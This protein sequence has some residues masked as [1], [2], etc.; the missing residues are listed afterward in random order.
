MTRKPAATDPLQDDIRLL[1]RLLGDT[2]AEQEGQDAFA[3][4]EQVRRLSVAY[5]RSGDAAAE[6]RLH[7]VLRGLSVEQMLSV[8]RAFTYFSH[9]ANLAEDRQHIRRRMWHE[10]LSHVQPGS[11]E[12]ALATLRQRGVSRQ[13]T[14]N[15]LAGAEVSPVLTAHPTEVQRQSVMLAERGISEL[16]TER[17]AIRQRALAV[18]AGLPAADR[19]AAQASSQAELAANE[20]GLR[21]HV[22]RL[23]QTRLLRD[24]RLTVRDE[25]ENALGYYRSTFLTEIPRLYERLEQRLPGADVAPFLRMGHWMGGDRDGNPNVDAGTLREA[26]TAQADLALAH[27][28]AEVHA[29][30]A[31]LPLSGLLIHVSPELAALAQQSPDHNPHRQDEP[32]RRVLSAIYARLAATRQRLT[33]G[34]L[35]HAG[36]RG[37]ALRQRRRAAG[38]AARDRRLA[39][40]ASGAGALAGGRCTRCSARCRCSAF[41]WPASICARAPTSTRPW[42]PSLLATA[43]VCPDYAALD[44]AARRALLLRLLADPR[45]PRCRA[46]ATARWP[47][48]S[49]RCS[50]PRRPCARRWA[51]PGRAPRHHQ[52]HRGGERPAR[53]AAAAKGDRPAAGH[54]GRGHHRACARRAD[55]GAACSK[56]SPTCGAPRPSCASSWPCPAWPTCC[57]PAAARRR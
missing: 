56:P 33:G 10:R 3:L 36:G 32:Y 21:A 34:L 43:G 30:G 31:E 11:L 38:R 17:D 16:L 44:E 40:R 25:I 19:R 57:A 51:R 28:L 54:A 18:P 8:I 49:W 2:I 27:Y 7:R 29:L 50:R 23:W 47:S 52:P 4:V 42:W 46:P 22:L 53:G 39:A 5:R 37:A 13:T 26:L 9:L 35:E 45:P 15:L 14:A 12:S 55:G 24:A 41:T 6:R 48:R 20:A 1:G